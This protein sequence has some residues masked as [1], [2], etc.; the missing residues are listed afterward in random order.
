MHRVLIVV[1]LVLFGALT[2]F[3]LY[4]HG[5]WGIIAPHFQSASAGQ[6]FADLVIALVLVLT[7]LWQDARATGRHNQLEARP[8]L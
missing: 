4:Q 2:P 5:Y 8:A 6:V 1:T 7:W 3:A